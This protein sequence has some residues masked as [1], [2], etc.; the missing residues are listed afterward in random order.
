MN[1]IWSE[2]EFII[3]MQNIVETSTNHL[4]VSKAMDIIE[5]YQRRQLRLQTPNVDQGVYPSLII[6]EDEDNAKSIN[7]DEPARRLRPRAS[8][9]SDS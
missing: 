3:R 8:E 4:N 5:K 9:A 1:T 2:K 7:N 6:K